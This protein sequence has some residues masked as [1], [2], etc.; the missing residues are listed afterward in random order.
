MYCRTFDKEKV[1]FF[2]SAFNISWLKIKII[3]LKMARPFSDNVNYI[4]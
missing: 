2:F 3:M 4:I 1:F